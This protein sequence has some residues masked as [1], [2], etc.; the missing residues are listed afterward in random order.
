MCKSILQPPL[1]QLDR[2]FQ[3]GVTDPVWPATPPPD[4]DPK[5][6]DEAYSGQLA[7]QRYLHIVT[8]D[9]TVGSRK[10]LDDLVHALSWYAKHQ[11]TRTPEMIIE[12]AYDPPAEN[13]RVTVTVGYG[14]TMFA[15]LQGDDRFGWSSFKPTWLKV[16]PTLK[17][18]DPTF[19]PGAYASDLII[20]LASDDAYVNEY[21]FGLLYYG[22]VHPG[23]KVRQLERGYARPDSREPG[24]FED[25]STNPRGGAPHS[26]MNNFVYID[27]GDD[28]PEWC[29]HGTYLAYRKIRRQL[30]DFFKLSLDQQQKLMGADKDT[31]DR[32][33]GAP[34]N[35]HKYKVNP[36][37]DVPDLFG[38]KDDE[39]QILRRPY[40]YDDGLDARG[41]DL[42]GVHHLSFVRNLGRQYEWRVQM[43]EMNPNFPE[44]NTGID[45]LYDPEGG[46]SN[47]GGG[48]YFVPGV[49]DQR[50][51]SPLDNRK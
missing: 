47:V 27:Q 2:P 34:P 30:V 10:N 4:I 3:P 18:D 43:W 22:H 8:A 39:R 21:L 16:I 37:R 5:L 51:R 35:C 24:G 6:Y 25:G 13:R 40:F 29:V 17:G 41:H 15:N 19:S 31:G 32:L 33:P 28:E 45:S 9:V 46:A 38:I 14:P 26:P 12:R 44:K 49:L 50:F 7:R 1:P 42:R 23:I 48:Y 36:N 11:M 20:L